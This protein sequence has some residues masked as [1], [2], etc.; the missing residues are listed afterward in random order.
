M[1]KRKSPVL[2]SNMS[3]GKLNEFILTHLYSIVGKSQQ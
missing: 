2:Q 3:G 1:Y